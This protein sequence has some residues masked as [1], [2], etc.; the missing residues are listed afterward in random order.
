MAP[1]FLRGGGDSLQVALS[2]S[3]IRVV[4]VRKEVDEADNLTLAF[5]VIDTLLDQLVHLGLDVSFLS[6]LGA[7]VSDGGSSTLTVVGVGLAVL[8]LR[9]IVKDFDRGEALD[10]ESLAELLLDITVDLAQLHLTLQIL[11]RL[12]VLRLQRFAVTAP[13]RVELHDP[14]VFRLEYG[15]VEAHLVEHD[16]VVAGCG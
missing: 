13:R 1:V 2:L 10:L 14:D 8:L 4:N 7:E 12:F 15:R 9:S 6:E 16:D 5:L 11:G 3:S